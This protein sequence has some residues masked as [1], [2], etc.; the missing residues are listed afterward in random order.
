M[1]YVQHVIEMRPV[2]AS[3]TGRRCLPPRMNRDSRVI[4]VLRLGRYIS[5]VGSMTNPTSFRMRQA[6]VAMA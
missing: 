3:R 2:L 1:R 4:G 5:G 6:Y